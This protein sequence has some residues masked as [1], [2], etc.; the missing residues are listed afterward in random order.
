VTSASLWVQ[1]ARPR[2]LGAAVAPVLVG[3]SAAVAEADGVVWWRFGCALVVALALQVGVNYANDYSDGVRGTDRDRKGP[4]RLTATGLATPGAVKRAAFLSFGVAAVAGLVLSLVVNPWLLLVG[5]AAIAAA[6]L[7]TGGPKPYGYL[8]LGELMVLV[9]FG[10]VATVGSAYVQ[11]KEVPAAAWW[12]SLVVGLLACA[13]LLANNVRDVPTDS[14]TGKR[15][16]AVRLGAA[17]GKRLFVAC[18]VGSFAS[19]AIIGISLHAQALLG[20]LALP[21]AVAPVR[22]MLT[23]SD[24]PSLVAVLVGTS[25]VE[26]VVA[27]LVSVGLCLS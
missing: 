23:R 16:L 7:Y 15:T 11:V 24:P 21:L 26:V 1:G 25:K 27:V 13:I 14:V 10:F 17:T 22:T 20:L 4:V 18:Y 6:W 12:G 2:T 5:V 8:G 19:V 9:F 3:T